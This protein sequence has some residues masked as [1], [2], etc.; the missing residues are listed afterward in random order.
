MNIKEKYLKCL[1][2][3]YYF[4]NKYCYIQY[5]DKIL[6]PNIIKKDYERFIEFIS[7]QNR[8]KTR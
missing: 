8:R 3:Q 5:K 7:K 2:D 6:N 1:K 4:I